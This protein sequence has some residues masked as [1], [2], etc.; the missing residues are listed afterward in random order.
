MILWLLSVFS[1]STLSIHMENIRYFPLQLYPST[2]RT[3]H[4]ATN[5]PKLEHAWFAIYAYIFMHYWRDK[6]TTLLSDLTYKW[7]G[8]FI[9]LQNNI[10][11]PAVLLFYFPCIII[12]SNLDVR[13]LKS[14]PKWVETYSLWL[15]FISP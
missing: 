7:R 9:S 11:I 5:L 8:C 10:S 4:L 13:W 14:R 15:V 1:S 3:N 6:R 12:F 2:W